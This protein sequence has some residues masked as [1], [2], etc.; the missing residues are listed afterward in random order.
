MTFVPATVQV[1]AV[2]PS[3]VAP[4][5]APPLALVLE[6]DCVVVTVE[7]VVTVTVVDVMPPSARVLVETDVVVPVTTVVPVLFECDP[8]EFDVLC[9]LF[10]PEGLLSKP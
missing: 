3:P 9:E 8:V 1:R 5:S 6:F 10:D 2:P 7:L 4:P